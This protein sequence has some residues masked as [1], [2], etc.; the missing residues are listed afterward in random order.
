MIKHFTRLSTGESFG[1]ESQSDIASKVFSIN[2]NV[3][4]DLD[5]CLQDISFAEESAYGVI[6]IIS[7]LQTVI[8][9]SS[10]RKK[11]YS[12]RLVPNPSG[13][14][15]SVEFKHPLMFDKNNSQG[16]KVKKGLG[17]NLVHARLVVDELNI[18]LKDYG[19]WSNE[20]TEEASKRFKEKT[21]DIFYRTMKHDEDTLHSEE[22]VLMH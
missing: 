14:S 8:G 3:D 21:L 16:R 5:N 15:F 2:P 6:Q 11:V 18:L 22:P 9:H 4:K 1:Y 12:A 19:Y 17:K 7:Y 20:G 10:E 13:T